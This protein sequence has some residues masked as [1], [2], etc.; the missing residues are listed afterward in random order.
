MIRIALLIVLSAS[1]SASARGRFERFCTRSDFGRT[2]RGLPC[3]GAFFQ[4]GGAGVS[5]TCACANVTG[6]KGEV[7]TT[8]RASVLDCRKQGPTVTSGITVGDVVT[9]GNNLPRVELMPD[10]VTRGVEQWHGFVETALRTDEL[11]NAIWT[12]TEPPTPNA[13][14]APD[15]T[16]TAEQLNDTNAGVLSCSSQTITTS[17]LTRQQVSAYVRAGTVTSATISL[18]GVGNSAGD[19]SATA[20]G[21]STTTWNRLWCAS[22]AAYAA[23]L[24]AVTVSVCVGTV[25]GDVGTVM[26]WRYNHHV[27]SPAL[28]IGFPSPSVQA[29]GSSVTV[30]GGATSGERFS[31]ALPSGLSQSFG[32]TAI[33]FAPAWAST[34]SNATNPALGSNLLFFDS[35]GRAAYSAG[36]GSGA[37]RIFDGTNDINHTPTA[38]AA[39]A[40]V[41][42]WSS[43][44]SGLSISGNG[45]APSTGAFDGTF[46]AGALTALSVADAFNVASIAGVFTALC[47]DPESTRC[48]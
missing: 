44:G 42:V 11:D 27:A 48:R 33:T 36:Y 9:C 20:T 29:V 19:C 2:E 38:W 22:P 18:V 47:A 34:A 23:G 10:G 5:D 7:L 4:F 8:T 24:T 12:S 1:A 6:T 39:G 35:A 21:L 31:F 16:L 25:V 37:V 15:N 14:T 41:R 13:A 26:A 40:T 17:S 28:G 45:A 3:G 46:G 43:W 30:A 32:S